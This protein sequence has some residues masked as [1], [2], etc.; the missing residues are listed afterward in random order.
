MEYYNDKEGKKGCRL[1]TCSNY[2]SCENKKIVFRTRDANYSINILKL[3]KC[4][5]EKQTRPIEFQEQILSFTTSS[6][7]NEDEKVT[8]S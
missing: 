1:L 4:W 6:K 2:V 5:I 7:N 8:S 3:T